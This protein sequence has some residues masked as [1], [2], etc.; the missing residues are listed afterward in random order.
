MMLRFMNKKG[1]RVFSIIII[2]LLIVS[3]VLTAILPFI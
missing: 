1:T 2:G 3:M